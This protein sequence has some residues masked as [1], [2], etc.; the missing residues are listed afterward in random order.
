MRTKG[1]RGIRVGGWAVVGVALGA[2]SVC[3]GCAASRGVSAQTPVIVQGAAV[4]GREGFYRAGPLTFGPQPDAATL[5]AFRA[6][7]TTTII[8]LRSQEEMADLIAEEGLDEAALLS[9]SG[10]RYIHIPLG[11]D[12]GYEPADVEAFAAAVESA[13][14]PVLI[15]CLS[16]GRART[17]WQAYLVKH[18]GY[19][20]PEAEA[21]TA[22]I[23]GGPSAL[24]QLLG[25]DVNLRLGDELP[26]AP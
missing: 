18:R 17:M 2:A 21:I 26:K 11:G 16:G 5:D 8:N 19:S 14:G 7:G 15:H 13:P 10:V 23:G 24:E 22:S 9:G 3:G 25:R 12:D 20:L 4:D 6:E 1:E